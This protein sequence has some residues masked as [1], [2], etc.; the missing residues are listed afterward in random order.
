[1]SFI[2]SI[3][4]PFALSLSK[5]ERHR[6]SFDGLRTNGRIEYI[7]SLAGRIHSVKNLYTVVDRYTCPGFR[8]VVGKSG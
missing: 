5:R 7:L 3:K 2:S 8:T 1:M 6:S 4:V